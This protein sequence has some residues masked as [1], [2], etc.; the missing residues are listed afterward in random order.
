MSPWVLYNPSTCIVQIK[1]ALD[2]LSPPIWRRVLMDDYDSLG[3]L[4]EVIQRVMPWNDGHC[5]CFTILNEYYERNPMT[6]I[7]EARREEDYML[8]TVISWGVKKFKYSYDYGDSWEHTI[9]IEK[10]LPMDPSLRYPVCIK[11]KYGCPP[12]DCGGTDGYIGMLQTLRA[13]GDSE[14]KQEYLEWLGGPFDPFVFDMDQA[15]ERLEELRPRRRAPKE[16]GPKKTKSTTSGKSKLSKKGTQTKEKQSDEKVKGKKN[17]KATKTKPKAGEKA[18]N[19]E[20]KTTTA[21]KGRAK[22]TSTTS[23]TQ[24][25]AKSNKKRESKPKTKRGKASTV[26]KRERVERKQT[27]A[28]KK[29]SKVKRVSS[30]IKKGTSRK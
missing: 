26:G 19:V 4:H 13:P 16:S 14:E 22:K 9:E 2:G 21:S 15:N 24:Q 28:Q 29:N 18:K 1:I 20:K 10:T 6:E 3:V 5:H 11:G 17:V 8:Q 25:K 27:A 30:S 23:S 7:R 12:D